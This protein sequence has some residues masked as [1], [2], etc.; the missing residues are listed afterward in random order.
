[1]TQ[2]CQVILLHTLTFLNHESSEQYILIKCGKGGQIHTM[3][4]KG[5]QSV[6]PNIVAQQLYDRGIGE[7]HTDYK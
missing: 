4:G 3:L 1:M 5:W 2:Y 6:K 7:T